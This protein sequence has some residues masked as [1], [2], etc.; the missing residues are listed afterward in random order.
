[1]YGSID[2]LLLSTFPW[3]VTWRAFAVEKRPLAKQFLFGLLA[4]AMILVITTGYH[5]GYSD[6]RSRKVLMANVGNTLMSLPT[7]LSSNPVGSPITH[8]TMHITA[9]L[10]SPKTDLFIPPHRE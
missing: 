9:V 4:L 10:H 5:L 6:F 3:I 7:L 8:A 2:G 1:V